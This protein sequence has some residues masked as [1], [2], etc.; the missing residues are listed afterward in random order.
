ML[1]GPEATILCILFVK[2]RVFAGNENPAKASEFPRQPWFIPSAQWAREFRW[3]P[4]E[5][6]FA[7]VDMSVKGSLFSFAERFDEPH[8]PEG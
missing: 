1:R 5:I 3:M 8:A 2:A 7:Y 4:A 6:F